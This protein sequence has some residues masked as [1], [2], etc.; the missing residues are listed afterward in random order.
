MCLPPANLSSLHS[1]VS[2]GLYEIWMTAVVNKLIP[3]TVSEYSTDW[4]LELMGINRG[5]E[6]PVWEKLRSWLLGDLIE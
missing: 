1:Y 4:Q 6:A 3:Y 2:V 5:K